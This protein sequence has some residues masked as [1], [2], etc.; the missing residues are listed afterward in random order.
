MSRKLFTKVD[1]NPPF[2]RGSPRIGWDAFLGSIASS[3]YSG[4]YAYTYAASQ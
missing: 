1:Y 2:S 4:Y 3:A